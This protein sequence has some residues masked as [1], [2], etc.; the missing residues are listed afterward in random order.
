MRYRLLIVLFA[1]GVAGLLLTS[2]QPGLGQ[3]EGKKA[4]K[5]KKDKGDAAQWAQREFQKRDKNEDGFLDA[6]EVPG[7]LRDEFERY[8]TNRDGKIDLHE[9][10]NHLQARAEEKLAK[11]REKWG[12]LASGKG[13]A[14]EQWA[15]GE[16]EKRDDDG[17]GFLSGKEPPGSL[18]DEFERWDTNRDGKIDPREFR[19]HLQARVQEKLQKAEQKAGQRLG[20]PPTPR[21]VTEDAEDAPVVIYRAG[22]LPPGLPA[23]FAELDRNRDGQVSLLEWQRGGKPF[24]EFRRMDRNDDGLLTI[25]ELQRFLALANGPPTEPSED[26]IVLVPPEGPAAK[27]TASTRPV[28]QR[29]EKKD[30]GKKGKNWR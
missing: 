26:S 10:R 9:L 14:F 5:D 11:G 8:D 24:R 2:A 29:Q 17:D 30:K 12:P 4:K 23:W 28:D 7:K 22:K 15:S 1:L 19:A 6:D 16:F 18:R 13:E 21:V 25:E 3:P 20:T 27:M